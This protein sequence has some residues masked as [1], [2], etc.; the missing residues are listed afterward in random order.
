MLYKFVTYV[1]VFFLNTLHLTFNILL[2]EIIM[3][4]HMSISIGSMDD[5]QHRY[6]FSLQKNTFTMYRKGKN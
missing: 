6:T 3:N 1:H 4:T 2:I 5:K